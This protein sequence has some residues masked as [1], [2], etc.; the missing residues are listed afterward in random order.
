MTTRNNIF[1]DPLNDAL[2]IATAI[3]Y[4]KKQIDKL[5]GEIDEL[6]EQRTPQTLVEYVQGPSGPKGEQGPRGFIG[7]VGPQGLQ[8]ERGLQ[9]E[10]GDKGDRGDSGLPGPIGMRGPQG[11]TGP[12][13]PQGPKGEKGDK[14]DKGDIGPQGAQGERGEKG[15]KGDK[16]DPG[17][18]GSDGRDGAPGPMGPAGPAGPQG[19]QGERGPS[20]EP[21]RTGSQGIQGERGPQGEA[22][23]QGVQGPPGKDGKDADIAPIV[24]DLESRITS[25][26]NQL[27]KDLAEYK[28]KIQQAISSGMI[29]IGSSGGGEVNLRYLDDVDTSNLTDGYILRYNAV[30]KKFEFV[31]PSAASFNPLDVTQVFAEV[32]NAES[33][34]ITK[35]QAVYLFSATGNKA[36]VK[37]ASNIGDATSAKTFGLVYSDSISAGG[38]GYIITQGVVSGVNTNEYQEG[39]T[40]YLANTPGGLTSTKPYAPNHLVY[41]GVVERANQGQGQ[42]YVRPQ[43]GY[44]LN[45]IHDVNINHNVALANGHIIVYNSTLELWENRP[46]SYLGVNASDDSARLTA[47]AAYQ[48]ANS[49]F[50]QANTAT[51]LAISAF[52]QANAAFNAANTIQAGDSLDVKYTNSTASSYKVIALNSNAEMILATSKNLTFIDRIVG[53]LDSTNNTV[54]FGVVEN[55][56]WSWTPEQSLFLGDN[57]E[58]VTTSTIDGAAFS[59]KL[60][61]AINQ[62]KMFVKIG[63]PVIL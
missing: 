36:S 26:Q 46:I 37:L 48:Q 13:G 5:K 34:P 30:T 50:N 1:D 52:A 33:F 45:E 19:I 18:D 15:D 16:G 40:L 12:Q 54:A 55:N 35:G 24:A 29:A 2:K 32:K 47:N 27:A 8:G 49:A 28:K 51:S 14:G 11:E 44:E 42:I 43:N 39:D 53:V 4:T 25:F 59:L 56:S 31:A 20:G 22:G 23:P 63:T 17:K 62:T 7:P 41:I 61:Y 3:A 38:T 10:K 58:I 21:G 6:K 9:G 57:G 60:G